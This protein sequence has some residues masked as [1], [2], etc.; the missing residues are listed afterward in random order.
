MVWPDRGS[1]VLQHDESDLAAVGQDVDAAVSSLLTQ[2]LAAAERA[3]RAAH[4]RLRAACQAHYAGGG[5]R[6]VTMPREQASLLFENWYEAP[7]RTR[8][9]SDQVRVPL[10][11]YRISRDERNTYV[12]YD[13]EVPEGHLPQYILDDARRCYALD[14]IRCR[15]MAAG[16]SRAE[17]PA[18]AR[19]DGG[20]SIVTLVSGAE[21]ST[22]EY[23]RRCA[24]NGLLRA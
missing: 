11:R 17:L 5:S 13:R 4:R 2:M 21:L 10:P 9:G 22:S 3:S 6:A 1:V 19:L 8:V 23:V 12:H 15:A 18:S 16:T 24:D 7:A 14:Q 20:A